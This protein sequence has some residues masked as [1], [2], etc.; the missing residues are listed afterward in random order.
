MKHQQILFY[1]GVC[2]LCHWAVRFAAKWAHKDVRFTALQGSLAK[3]TIGK[4]ID[5]TNI[6]TVVFLKGET[7]YTASDAFL[8]LAQNG[9]FPF[10]LCT[11]LLIIPKW[12]RDPVY[13]WVAKNRYRWFGKKTQCEIP[14]EA[15]RLRSLD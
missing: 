1:D 8:R 11:V 13:H 15:V 6:S 2:N 12:L 5:L 3:Q 4:H 14:N 7:C 9:K 10:N